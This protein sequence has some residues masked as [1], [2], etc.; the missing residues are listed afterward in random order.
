VASPASLKESDTTSAVVGDSNE[1]V[2]QGV[3]K[4]ACTYGSACYR[5]NAAHLREFW[6]PSKSVL[7]S[8][9]HMLLPFRLSLSTLPLP[10]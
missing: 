8:L 2:G 5:K 1:D 7:H 9:L 10:C 3:Q 6:H 4:P